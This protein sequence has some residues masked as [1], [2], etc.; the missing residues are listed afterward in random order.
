M[1]ESRFTPPAPEAVL[2]RL[3]PILRETVFI[4]DRTFL[5]DHPGEADRL[6]KH[7]AVREAYQ[8]D[9][10]MPYWADLWPASRMLA[11]A[12]LHEP[13]TPGIDALEL[14]CGLGLPGIVA[15]TMGLRVTFTDYDACALRFAA[16]NARLNGQH[17]FRTLQLDWREPPEGL[18]SPVLLAAD[19]L[20]ELRSVEPLARCIKTLLAPNGVCLL[21]DI[22]RIPASALRAALDAAGLAY[23]TKMMRAGEP[24][25]R[26]VKGT[27]YR[28]G[29][30]V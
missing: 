26:R 23:T 1:S 25:G 6:A 18:Q 14:G 15:M 5:I 13:W 2:D 16:D 10:Y 21:A 19:L 17:D 24:G 8:R 29:H 27:L 20:Y 3:G 30:A 7:P 12:V 4:E 22:E 28:I 9:A 11:R